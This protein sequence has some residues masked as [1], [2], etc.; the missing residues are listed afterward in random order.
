[1]P[2]FDYIES[3]IEKVR[4]KRTHCLPAAYILGVIPYVWIPE[5]LKP[6][7]G[8]DKAQECEEFVM[9]IRDD[10][11]KISKVELRITEVTK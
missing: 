7:L 5:E 4:K 11:S 8:P 6:L 9:K 10:F 2:M 1:M 3:L